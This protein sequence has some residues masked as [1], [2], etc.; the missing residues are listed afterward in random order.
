MKLT[1][2]EQIRI[3]LKRKKWSV[4]DLA[5]RLGTSR[6]NVNQLL[7]KDNFRVSDIEKIAGV[8]GCDLVIEL[9]EKPPE[10]L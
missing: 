6:Q 1:V 8:L 9:K 10:S 3:I 5:E 2:S 4:A 7:I